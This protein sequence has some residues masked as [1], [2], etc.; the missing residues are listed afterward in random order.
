LVD[1]H[2]VTWGTH[3]IVLIDDLDIRVLNRKTGHSSA[4]SP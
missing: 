1:N 2:P 3:V 4:N